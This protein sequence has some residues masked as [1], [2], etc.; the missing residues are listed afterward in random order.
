M[1]TTA[2][3][4]HGSAVPRLE[5]K[6]TTTANKSATSDEIKVCTRM[7]DT[8]NSR[9]GY[10]CEAT[11]PCEAGGRP[12]ICRGCESVPA[13]CGKSAAQCE[14]ALWKANEYERGHA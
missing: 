5:A 10:V 9:K 2:K 3:S 11:T 7:D 4:E 13:S 14:M 6:G 8:C 1:T 12:W